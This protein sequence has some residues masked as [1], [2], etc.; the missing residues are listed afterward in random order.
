MYRLSSQAAEPDR[1]IIM[2]D[3]S[4]HWFVRGLK[5][6]TRSIPSPSSSTAP[7]SEQNK[8]H[9]GVHYFGTSKYYGSIFSTSSPNHEYPCNVHNDKQV[10]S[11]TPWPWDLQRPHYLKSYARYK[12]SIHGLNL[13][14]KN[15]FNFISQWYNMYMK[16]T[17]VSTF[18]RN[19]EA[20]TSSIGED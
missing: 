4:V 2:D 11:H 12:L 3:S 6:C 5:H 18:G 9:M 13:K 1:A 17:R 10:R 8:K 20:G 15:C 7:P 19:P 16:S 14:N